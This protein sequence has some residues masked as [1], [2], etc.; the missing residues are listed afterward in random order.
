MHGERDLTTQKILIQNCLIQD[1][2][3]AILSNVIILF[4]NNDCRLVGYDTP[5]VSLD[6]YKNNLLSI[7]TQLKNANKIPFISNLQPI[8]E[9]LFRHTLPQVARYMKMIKSAYEW[10]K[11]YSDICRMIANAEKTVLLDIRS[12][13]EKYN[14]VISEDGLHPNDKGHQIIADQILEVLE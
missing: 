7:I 10:Q 13:L 3:R 8:N 1:S 4:G 12:N 6:E 2:L 11:Q 14:D 9:N 5:A